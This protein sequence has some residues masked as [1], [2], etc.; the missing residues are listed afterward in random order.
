METK[1]EYLPHSVISGLMSG[2]ETPEALP[3]VEASDQKNRTESRAQ[4]GYQVTLGL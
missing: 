3:S 2:L 4:N 1:K